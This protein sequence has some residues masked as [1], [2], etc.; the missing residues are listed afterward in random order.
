MISFLHL[1][2]HRSMIQGFNEAST[3]NILVNLVDI[4]SKYIEKIK[5]V[6]YLTFVLMSW[7]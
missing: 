4:F 7:K 6:K 3:V 2:V 1:H 5:S